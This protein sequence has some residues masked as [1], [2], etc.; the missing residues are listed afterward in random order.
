MLLQLVV[1]EQ[2]EQRHLAVDQLRRGR[3]GLPVLIGLD[4]RPGAVG[5]APADGQGLVK[6]RRPEVRFAENRG[7]FWVL[8][9]EP[10]K[11]P[12]VQSGVLLKSR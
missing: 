10:M 11:L 5:G 6:K 3:T 8:E 12:G 9:Y 7:G 1:E 4:R 2:I